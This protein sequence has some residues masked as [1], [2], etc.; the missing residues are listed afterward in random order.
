M[1]T[2]LLPEPSKMKARP[3]SV[4]KP[5]SPS[6]SGEP[7]MMVLPP[8]STAAPKCSPWFLAEAS[9]VFCSVHKAPLRV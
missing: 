9:S 7:T 8:M 2:Q 1:R 6:Q 3:M 4:T 5:L